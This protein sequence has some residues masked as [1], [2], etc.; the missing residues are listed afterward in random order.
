VTSPSPLGPEMLGERGH[1][2][3]L[4]LNREN[5][6][7]RYVSGSSH[8]YLDLRLRRDGGDASFVAVDSVAGTTYRTILRQRSSSA[9]AT[10][11]SSS[12]D[13]AGSA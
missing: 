1:D 13:H 5:P 6:S 2:F 7:V 8:G 10:A 9:D 4:L 12:V 3:G 11:I